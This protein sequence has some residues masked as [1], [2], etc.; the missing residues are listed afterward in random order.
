MERHVR[1][2]QAKLT[3]VTPPPEPF[4][5]KKIEKTQRF[6]PLSSL[7]DIGTFVFDLFGTIARS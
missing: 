3:G 6:N 1:L 2:F 5:K 7:C 4:L